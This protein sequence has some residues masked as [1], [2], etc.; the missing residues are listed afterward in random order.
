[1]LKNPIRRGIARLLE[2]LQRSAR[3]PSQ[4]A[5]PLRKIIVHVG[6]PKAASTSIQ[7]A[8]HGGQESLLTPAGIWFR[9]PNGEFSDY[10]LYDLLAAQDLAGIREYTDAKVAAAIEAGADTV[11]FSAERLFTI[12]PMNERMAQL[13][14]LLREWADEVSFAVV[15]RELKPFMRSYIVQMIYNGAVPLETPKLAEW[16]IDQARSVSDSGCAVDVLSLEQENGGRNIAEALLETTT[17]RPL[18][19]D[20]GRL[21]ATP[22]RPIIYALAEGLVA[23]LHSLDAAQDVNSGSMDQ[24]RTRFAHSFDESVKASPDRGEVHRVLYQLDALLEN[25]IEHYIDQSL[26]ICDPDKLAWYKQLLIAPEPETSD[27]TSKS[28]AAAA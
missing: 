18:A 10:V 14:E 20:L 17:G 4:P 16:I 1:M 25:K 13:A 8:L 27:E 22:V 28:I 11:I 26:A 6:M 5:R 19:I 9:A 2:A 23:R 15:V 21:N 24:Y 12:M 3:T 7:L